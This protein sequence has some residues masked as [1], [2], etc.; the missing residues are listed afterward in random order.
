MTDSS[1]PANCPRCG[2]AAQGN[3]CQS[4]GSSLSPGAC[5]SC[6]A[7]LPPGVRFCSACGAPTHAASTQATAQRGT[8]PAWAIAAAILVVLVAFIVGQRMGTSQTS[9]V[10]SANPAFGGF[11]GSGTPASD[12]SNL[13]PQEAASRL[14]DRVMRYASEGKADSAGMFAPMAIMA[15][16]RIG[17]LDAHARYDVGS[18][19]LVTGD[20]AGAAAQ[21]DTIL[22]QNSTHL[23]G[24][25]LA[26]RAAD[27][28]SKPADA[29]RYRSRFATA[30]KTERAKTLPEYTDHERDIDDALK[31]PTSRP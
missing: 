31:A 20:A 23:L 10:A 27:A 24:L 25:L 4:C 3:F 21:A 12:I 6:G 2:A 11:A 15:Y 22:K 5:A 14:F 8:P 19:S 29:A 1:K 9:P 17:P 26:A 13:T 30:V 7:D 16:E 18:I 28:L